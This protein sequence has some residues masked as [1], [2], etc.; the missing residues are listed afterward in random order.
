[1]KARV[2]RLEGGGESLLA[3]I[4]LLQGSSITFNV[5]YA[6]ISVM[7]LYIHSIIDIEMKKSIASETSVQ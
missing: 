3:I 7:C 4:S 2:I 1:M 6:A 5:F